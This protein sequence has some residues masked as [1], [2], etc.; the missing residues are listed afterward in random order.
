M[1]IRRSDV[2]L[3]KGVAFLDALPLLEQDRDPILNEWS[4][5]IVL[6]IQPQRVGPLLL[7]RIDTRHHP[8]NQNRVP[9]VPLVDDGTVGA[10]TLEHV[11]GDC[12]NEVASLDVRRD[13][14]GGPGEGG[15]PNASAPLSGQEA[16]RIDEDSPVLCELLQQPGLPVADSCLAAKGEDESADDDLLG[17]ERGQDPHLASGKTEGRQQLGRRV[18]RHGLARAKRGLESDDVGHD[19]AAPGLRSASRR[20]LEDATVEERDRAG[21]VSDHAPE[22]V[23]HRRQRIGLVRLCDE[24]TSDRVE[25]LEKNTLVALD[26]QLLENLDGL[27]GDV[28][29]PVEVLP[30]ALGIDARLPP[31]GQH[32]QRA[33]LVVQGNRGRLGGLPSRACVRLVLVGDGRS[34]D[35]L[36]GLGVD[37]HDSTAGGVDCIGDVSHQ[38]LHGLPVLLAQEADDRPCHFPLASVPVLAR[39][40]CRD[41]TRSIPAAARTAVIAT[42]PRAALARKAGRRRARG[43]R[44]SS[45]EH[46]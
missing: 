6:Q 21:I 32:A 37:E 13:D 42:R 8:G 28:G 17:D 10:R 34:D 3:A 46:G 20:D 33:P 16:L 15:S 31:G 22:V 29:H 45:P 25:A 27:R 26:G 9:R 44:S 5:I 19:H 11:L 36:L 4:Q 7:G 41:S 12:L 1:G 30:E 43:D 23:E 18:Q 35:E 38:R 40:G 39:I 14:S 24:S 2:V